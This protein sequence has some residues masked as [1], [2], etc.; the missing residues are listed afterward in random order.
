MMLNVFF[1]I[2]LIYIRKYEYNV[3]M[4]FEDFNQRSSPL[5][6][7]AP[8]LFT[9]S[10]CMVNPR[11]VLY[12]P[13]KFSAVAPQLTVLINVSTPVPIPWVVSYDC[14]RLPVGCLPLV[15][16][17][18]QD[19]YFFPSFTN[20]L[21]SLSLDIHIFPDALSSVSR[22]DLLQSVTSRYRVVPS[23]T[24]LFIGVV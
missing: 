20:E 5:D 16:V 19:S 1:P 8:C 14:E 4:S 6:L 7:T 23:V 18:I 15:I 11:V 10:S 13:Y 9:P 24:P 3:F 17:W 21:R 2:Y 12:I 22:K